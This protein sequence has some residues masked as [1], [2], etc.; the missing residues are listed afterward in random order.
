MPLAER[1]RENQAVDC[2][3]CPSAA[4]RHSPENRRIKQ[5]LNLKR[6]GG[7]ECGLQSL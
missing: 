4:A 5:P 2:A 3:V 7:G 6:Q 1:L